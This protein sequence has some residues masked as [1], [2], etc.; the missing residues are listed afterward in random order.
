L[1]RPV[2]EPRET[3]VTDFDDAL[4]GDEYVGWFEVAVED[5]GGVEGDEAVEKLVDE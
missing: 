3:Q 5:V 2:T 4:G 1:E